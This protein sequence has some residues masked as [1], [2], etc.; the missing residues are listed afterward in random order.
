MPDYNTY[1]EEL[2]NCLVQATDCLSKAAEYAYHSRTNE[3]GERN[4][5]QLSLLLITLTTAVG[6]ENY[7]G[8]ETFVV[9]TR[10]QRE[11]LRLSNQAHSKKSLEDIDSE[12]PFPVD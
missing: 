1:L 4:Y 6:I 11:S 2:Q 8:I 12:S 3:G 9:N 5:Y 7:K 10:G